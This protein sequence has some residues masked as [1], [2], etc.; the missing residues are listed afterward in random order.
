MEI[1]REELVN[2]LE[3]INKKQ[4]FT[5]SQK[6]ENQG[7]NL[8]HYAIFENKTRFVISILHLFE[9]ELN[10]KNEKGNTPLH[11]A[12]LKGDL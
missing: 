12:C 2:F 11:H 5:I 7:D 3:A 10:L 1:V 8:L 9:N 6:D 4:L